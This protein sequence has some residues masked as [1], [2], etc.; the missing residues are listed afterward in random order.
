MTTAHRS[1]L[2][3]AAAGEG[4][5]A[6]YARGYQWGASHRV[7]QGTSSLQDPAGPWLSGGIR[8]ED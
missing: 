2:G 1:S 4:Y 7:P 3:E 5:R 8:A 6:V